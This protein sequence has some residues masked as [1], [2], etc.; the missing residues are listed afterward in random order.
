LTSGADDALL[1][2]PNTGVGELAGPATLQ[3]AGFTGDM[4]GASIAVYGSGG[5]DLAL[6]G[7]RY[8]SEEESEPAI[9]LIKTTGVEAGKVDGALWA[10][11]SETENSEAKAARP[12]QKS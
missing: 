3:E 2:D 4:D 10:G 8:T 9:E 11:V 12:R 6:A 1:P 7:N 5:A